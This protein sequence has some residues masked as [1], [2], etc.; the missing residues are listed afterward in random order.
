MNSLLALIS[1]QESVALPALLR[2][3]KYHIESE[4]KDIPDAVTST[5]VKLCRT[6]EYCNSVTICPNSPFRS[7]T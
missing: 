3:V 7:N 5:T 2:A 6:L 1:S 4:A